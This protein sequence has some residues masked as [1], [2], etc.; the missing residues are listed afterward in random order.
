MKAD[1]LHLA[2]RAVQTPA[3]A[4]L[5]IIDGRQGKAEAPKARGRAFQLIAEEARATPVVMASMYYLYF[6]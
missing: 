3:P 5:R 6:Y 1:R 2:S 4:T